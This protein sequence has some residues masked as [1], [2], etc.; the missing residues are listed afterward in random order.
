MNDELLK[1]VD[2]KLFYGVDDG[3]M[4]VNETKDTITKIQLFE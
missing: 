1:V 2:G 4:P 3:I